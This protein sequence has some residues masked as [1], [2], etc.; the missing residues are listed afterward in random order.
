[1]R[2]VA[3]GLVSG[4]GV[5][6]QYFWN[7]MT[8]GN[9][10]KEDGRSAELEARAGWPQRTQRSQRKRIKITITI[11]IKSGIWIRRAG[12]I[13]SGCIPG[14]VGAG[15]DGRA[16]SGGAGR[17]PGGS[18]ALDDVRWLRLPALR[19]GRSSRGDPAFR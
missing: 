3:C 15:G 2:A 13:W 5:A 9:E 6:R 7:G 10:G 14:K 19:C 8:E 12:V 18:R 16:K 1:M 4:F 11:T 17:S